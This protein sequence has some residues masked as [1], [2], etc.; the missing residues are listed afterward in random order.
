[1]EYDKLFLG[2]YPLIL[3]QAHKVEGFGGVI[4]QFTFNGFPWLEKLN[5]PYRI[6]QARAY[7]N[8]N[9]TAKFLKRYDSAPYRTMTFKSKHSYI[10]LPTLKAYSATNIF[11]QVSVHLSLSLSLDHFPKYKLYKF[12]F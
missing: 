8:V 2:C 10:G 4:Q 9:V 1:M 3:N 6:N 12:S 11:F 7:P 5:I